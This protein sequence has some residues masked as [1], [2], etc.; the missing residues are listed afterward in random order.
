[1]ARRIVL[2]NGS[3]A[4]AIGMGRLG[5]VARKD[6]MEFTWNSVPVETLSIRDVC[7]FTDRQDR[8]RLEFK[9]SRRKNLQILDGSHLIARLWVASEDRM[10]GMSGTISYMDMMALLDWYGLDARRFFERGSGETD[11]GNGLD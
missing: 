11:G 2:D 7:S 8:L 5:L 1:M 9:E 3:H 6:S 10:C 4:L